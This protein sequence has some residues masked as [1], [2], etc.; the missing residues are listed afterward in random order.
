VQDGSSGRDIIGAGNH[1]GRLFFLER[2][3]RSGSGY[4]ID[5]HE[6]RRNELETEMARAGGLHGGGPGRRDRQPKTS[7]PRQDGV[8]AGAVSAADRGQIVA[9]GSV[10]SADRGQNVSFRCA[11]GH[12]RPGRRR[13]PETG[14]LSHGAATRRGRPQGTE[15]KTGDHGAEPDREQN[16]RWRRRRP[17]REQGRRTEEIE[18]RIGIKHELRVRERDKTFALIPC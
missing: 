18:N 6:H 16:G 7:L 13:G 14:T 2:E 12:Q 10:G 5:P 1:A 3:T 15:T 4:P 9:D 17:G 11:R 8:P